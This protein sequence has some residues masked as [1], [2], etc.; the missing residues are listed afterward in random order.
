MTKKMF[1]LGSGG[2]KKP[3]QAGIPDE[4]LPFVSPP[5]PP[6]SQPEPPATHP[7]DNQPAFDPENTAQT[8][9]GGPP[10]VYP[11]IVMTP[12]PASSSSSTRPKKTQPEKETLAKPLIAVP[13][14]LV[15]AVVKPDISALELEHSWS[16]EFRLHQL[17]LEYKDDLVRDVVTSHRHERVFDFYLDDPIAYLKNFAEHG[18]DEESDEL[19]EEYIEKYVEEIKLWN[20]QREQRVLKVMQAVIEDLSNDR[21]ESVIAIDLDTGDKVFKRPG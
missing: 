17:R 18:W 7:Q 6:D 4:L 11:G 3:A 9:F 16:S 1:I 10:P 14:D 21:Y 19:A 13:A 8:V 2:G 5:S 12:P 15:Q 20:A